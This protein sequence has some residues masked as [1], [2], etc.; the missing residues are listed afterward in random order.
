MSRFING[1]TETVLLNTVLFVVDLARTTVHIFFFTMSEK[2]N[3][4]LIMS[5]EVI[6]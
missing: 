1:D 2:Q 5:N 6:S 4:C 3:L